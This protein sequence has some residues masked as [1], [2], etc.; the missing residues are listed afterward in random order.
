MKE[1]LEGQTGPQTQIEDFDTP[2]LVLVTKLCNS[3]VENK[4]VM[5]L[6]P[7]DNAC[8]WMI[9]S[10]VRIASRT[11][12][13]D[14]KTDSGARTADICIARRS[15]MVDSADRA[16]CPSRHSNS[17]YRFGQAPKRESKP[18]STERKREASSRN[19]VELT[20]SVSGACHLCGGELQIY[21][22]KNQP[23]WL[24]WICRYSTPWAIVQRSANC[25]KLCLIETANPEAD[26]R[27]AE[28]FPR[29]Q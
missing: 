20:A 21:P 19:C 14:E 8:R 7:Q 10:S 27:G 1:L 5:V 22:R 29:Q 9:F 2:P 17:C 15:S 11:G 16:Q 6:I 28:L 24:G 12:R 26:L 23:N 3:P 18:P 4:K 25:F 13:R